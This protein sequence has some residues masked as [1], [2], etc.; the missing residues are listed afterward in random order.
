MASFPGRT[1]SANSTP[2]TLLALPAE[3]KLLILLCLPGR[4]IQACRRICREFTELIDSRDNQKAI[5]DPIRRRVA[6]H[7]W[8]LLTLFTP[9]YRTSLPAF[10]F[11]WISCRGIWPY[12][13]RNRSIVTT[14]ARQ[15]AVQS[16]HKILQMV[17]MVNDTNTATPAILTVVLDG[18]SRLLGIIAEALA[19]AYIDVH[20]P[21]LFASASDTSMRMCDVSTRQKFFSLIDSRINQ[22]NL[23]YLMTRFGLPLSRAELGRWYGGIVT[24]QAPFFSRGDPALIDIP[25]GPSPKLAVPQFVLTSF[26]Y[27]Y[28]EQ[29]ST[30]STEDSYSPEVRVQGRCAADDLSRI[31]HWRVPDLSPFAAWCVRSQ[32]A[33]NLICQALGGK[34]LT[35]MQRDTVMEDLYCF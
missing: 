23:Q 7:R 28:Q 17:S 6:K 15:W 31:L 25:R 33:D 2:P 32:W 5:I 34:V 12:V 1:P 19:Q 10:L 26:N 30:S 29:D 16:S 8:P 35:D 22:V 13:E 21:D 24:R 11:M 27:W 4:K 3:I 20:L 9:T 14:A 18:I